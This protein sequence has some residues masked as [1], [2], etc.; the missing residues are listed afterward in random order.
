MAIANSSFAEFTAKVNSTQVTEG[1]TINLVLTAS[2]TNDTSKPDLSV[3]NQDFVILNQQ[4]S[5]SMSIVNGR[6]SSKV[7][8]QL[9]LLPKRTGNVTIPAIKQGQAQSKPI[10]I[11]ISTAPK[12]QKV[13]T[14]NSV[15]VESSL[16]RD[17]VFLGGQSLL[18]LKIMHRGNMVGA[19]LDDPAAENATI[20]QVHENSYQRVIDGTAVAIIERVYAVFPETEGPITIASQLLQ[21]ELATSNQR[22]I[23]GRTNTK[24]IVRKSKP[25]T[26]NALPLPSFAEN[27]DTVT[28]DKLSLKQS[29]GE[30]LNNLKVGDSITRT[31]LI[32]ATGSTSVQIPP[33]F[34]ADI[35]G[36]KQYRDQPTLEDSNS[37]TGV[38][39]KRKESIAYVLTEAGTFEIP[40]LVMYW[41]NAKTGK[42]HSVSVPS[43]QIKVAAAIANTT[44]LDPTATIPDEVVGT[45]RQQAPQTVSPQNNVVWFYSTIV[46]SVLWFISLI[47]WYLHLRQ[48]KSTELSISPAMQTEE[49]LF[50]QL[51]KYCKANDAKYT[52]LLF[53]QWGRSVNNKLNSNTAI[54]QYLNT[55]EV[56]KS[57]LRAEKSLYDANYTGSWSGA[58]LASHL[59]QI[60][61]QLL[62]NKHTTEL[63]PLYR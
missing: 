47:C 58:Q 41:V 50:K 3:L 17:S 4:Q 63:T 38:I 24:K 61:E 49:K 23:F 9:S 35:N 18:T 29:W 11:K 42:L 7:D 45:N 1:D 34:L 39:G 46:L 57:I 15:I 55:Q 36:I 32:E 16:D 22:S 62:K 59:K 26:L 6:R 40:S 10:T 5:Q 12:D 48:V 21:A 2:N 27:K 37:Q 31:L 60:R 43:T 56:D 33:I 28:A 14:A 52:L 54:C 20:Q 51:I 13:P 44:P 25:Q 30:R 53:K 8:W 19:S